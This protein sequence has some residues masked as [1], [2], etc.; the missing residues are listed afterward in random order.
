M[1]ARAMRFEDEKRRI[2]ES[3]FSKKD[4]DGSLLETY[5][6]HVR[7]T[8]YSSY[9]TSPPPPQ[10]RGQ[11]A[12][13]PRIII[14]A[15][16]KSGRVRMHKSKENTNGTFSIGKTWNL[17][18]LTTVES[19][20]GPTATAQNREWAGDTGFTVTIGKPYFWNA[21]SDKEKKFFIASL[22]KIFGKYT[23]GRTPELTGF[24]QRE[25]DQVLGG[26]RRPPPPQ[27]HQGQPPSRPTTSDQQQGL[28]RPPP[29]QNPGQP[30]SRPTT[31]DQQQ[32]PSRPPMPE[33][34]SSNVSGFSA[35]SSTI[36]TNA[37]AASNYSL[38]QT[39]VPPPA[40]RSPYMQNGTNSSSGSVN[41]SISQNQPA[42]NRLASAN[43]S[44]ESVAASFATRSDDASS[45]PPRS[46][47]G[48][49]GPGA[50]GRYGDT[51]EQVPTIQPQTQDER[52]PERKRP[53]MD[54]LR[55]QGIADKDL[56]PAPLMSPSMRRDPV[57]PPPR[58]VDRMSPRKPSISQRSESNSYKE[59]P[60][61][62]GSFKD[63]PV[64][65]A[66]SEAAPPPSNDGPGDLK[67]PRNG[68]VSTV[69]SAAPMAVPEPP[70][71]P[72]PVDNAV[73][74]EES[75]PGLG[76]MIKSKKS[77][78]EIAG[79]FW[80]AASAANA[81]KPRP[82][83]AGERLRLAATK[84]SEDGSDGITGVFQPPPR[85][86]SSD[87]DKTQV[88]EP[89]PAADAV[90]P[91][92]EVKITVPNS[93]RPASLQPS[94]KEVKP[95]EIEAVKTDDAMRKDDPRKFVVA[96]NDARYLA[97]LGVDPS[98]MNNKSSE[99]TKWLDFFGWVPGQQM[100][101]RH[102][103]ELRIDV[104]RELNKAQAGGWLARFKEDDDR[105]DGIKGGID[106]AIAECE[107]LDN[108]LTL[109]SVELSTLSDDIAYIE[110]QGQGLQ[111]QTANQK[112]LRKE[113][114][115]LLETTAI[116]SND[117]GALRGAPLENLNGL[118]DIERALVTLYKAMMKIDPTLGGDQSRK[119]NDG[120][121]DNDQSLGLDNSDYGK[122]RIVQEKK[123]MYMQESS[124]FMRRL[125]EYMARQFQEA[126]SETSRQLG[127]AL[128]RKVDSHH[129]DA[130]RDLL[131]KYSPL[132]LYAR[133]VD[134]KNW[135]RL[136]QLYQDLN[137]P[138]YKREF[139]QIMTAWKKNARKM[140]SD[141]TSELL[142]TSHAEK[143][144]EGIAT[145]AR[146]LTVK[147]SQTLAKS[148]RS[149]LDGSRSNLKSSEGQ[150]LP[151]E[152]FGSVLDD[153]LPLVE[154]EQNFIVDFFH[155]TTL[156][157]SDFP[158]AVAAFRPRDRQGGDLRRHRLMEP[159]RDL[160]RRVTKAMEV[161]FVFMENE[162]SGLVQWV[163]TVDNLQGVGVLAAMERKMA[164]ISQ[165]N[166]DF[167]NTLLQK[168]HSTLESRF[169][170]FVDEQIRAI[171]ETKVK[172]NKRKGVI[173]FIR[174][175]PNFSSAVENILNGVDKNLNIRGTV[176]REYDRIL[177]S[178]FDS[179]K[180]IARENPAVA[181][182]TGASAD[183]EDKEA[184]N[185]HILLIENANHFLEEVDARGLEV[186]EEWRANATA[187]LDEHMQLYIGAVMR[188]PLGK[189]LEYLENIEAQL[190]SG[191]PGTSIAAQPSNSRGVFNKVVGNYDAKE[192]RK[193]IETL[194]KRVEKHF[195]DADDPALSRNLVTKVLKEC[196]KFYGDVELRISRVTADVYN[197]DTLFEWPR[198]EVKSG[199]SGLGK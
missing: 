164:E 179:L 86:K 137:H 13:K 25:L 43:K 16:R 91:L 177:K 171:E 159:D 2:I 163:L 157:Q 167:L 63:R 103:D 34:V 199:F 45:L 144:E 176:D 122:M 134:L 93:S 5:I 73:D 28:G 110:A 111:V 97:T 161:I 129:H 107:E 22:I 57:A 10:A 24:D 120:G 47:N 147:R 146:K 151:Y 19:F 118:E 184:L 124:L 71:D 130:G 42:F 187:E 72:S 6:T 60:V 152:T 3:C 12:E 37:A 14:V 36:S 26:G 143:K 123:Q 64:T 30:P 88:A 194:R 52:P 133:D 169:K 190:A 51:A 70:P 85:P 106:T 115:S 41:S 148:L 116:T 189:L 162:L 192:V 174:I 117:L 198:A 77:K 138:V 80:K 126:T 89:T 186:L 39:A 100:R 7:I 29:L 58:S 1:D 175:F 92:P 87:A 105:V 132:I 78:G 188:R 195:G 96:G 158:D 140:S 149:P 173:S 178:M 150:S 74:D 55:P 155:A 31:S 156:D 46:R 101:S 139:Q 183:S 153:I 102:M 114:E 121:I 108:L 185:F 193:G 15:V 84:P 196:E 59:R 168:L 99:F 90:P 32:G 83:G 69:S 18:D 68:S 109:Y 128:S 20:T 181:V 125:V 172:I 113:L 54:P 21:Q 135:D 8:E 191:K 38:Q 165:T 53:P 76:P 79:A 48:Q 27:Q 9:P 141:E 61:T 17:D 65:P 66:A 160:A 67:P 127:E 180:I 112:T 75:R 170:K 11:N 82:G 98:I 56:V 166:Q 142:F 145:T 104:D 131:W 62:P 35:S 23:G 136:L 33:G 50:F 197:G 40:R 44:Q 4:V 49:P 95:A 94:I 182:N 119:S 81:F 154:M